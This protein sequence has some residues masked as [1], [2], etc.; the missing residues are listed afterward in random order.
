MAT[1]SAQS[2]SSVTIVRSG[3]RG[4]DLV[5]RGIRNGLIASVAMAM[6]MMVL[7]AFDQGFFAT[8]SAIWAF[9]AGPGAYTPHA[10]GASVVI[11][12]MG[13]MMNSAVLGIVFAFLAARL[14]RPEGAAASVLAGTTFALLVLAIMWKGVLPLSAN[15][16]I[17]KASAALWIWIVGH[18]AF[19]MVGGFLYHRWR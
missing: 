10:L 18:A 19:G 9:F 2:A 1:T 13:H 6:A 7:G 8:P 11:G 14:L 12:A 15:G 4:G 17:V 5:A 3:P 16:D